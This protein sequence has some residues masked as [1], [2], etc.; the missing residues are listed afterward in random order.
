MWPVDVVGESNIT[1]DHH[2]AHLL[3]AG[4]LNHEEWF[5][6]GAAVVGLPQNAT[7]EQQLMA[8]RGIRLATKEKDEDEESKMSADEKYAAN[9]MP[10]A[11]AQ[12]MPSFPVGSVA[13][14]AS[15]AASSTVVAAQ[16]PEDQS[17]SRGRKRKP[18]ADPS[19]TPG[20]G[21]R[22]STLRGPSSRSPSTSRSVS[23]QRGDDSLDTVE[24]RK[25]R[26]DSTGVVHFVANKLRMKGQGIAIDGETPKMLMVPCMT[27]EAARR[28]KGEGYKMAV[29]TGLPHGQTNSP[30][31]YGDIT[32]EAKN[33]FN[34]CFCY[35]QRQVCTTGRRDL[36]F[37]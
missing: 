26:V 36:S 2:I 25:Q 31:G 9:R 16:Q 18:K 32:Y 30:P 12:T 3:P 5:G 1:E 29:L 17:S 35:R 22:K 23:F 37:L 27:L 33:S 21:K 11:V 20:G 28:W 10:A 14:V 19:S 7:T 6:L 24:A 13:A 4:K 34:T 8:T 15:G